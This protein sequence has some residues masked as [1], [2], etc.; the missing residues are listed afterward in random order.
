MYSIPSFLIP[1][2]FFLAHYHWHKIEVLRRIINIVFFDTTK[3]LLIRT[4]TVIFFVVAR[5]VLGLSHINDR[6]HT[7]RRKESV[8][9]KHGLH[10]RKILILLHVAGVFAEPLPSTEN[11][12]IFLLASA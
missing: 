6:E 10:I 9:L 8:S 4:R 12:E 7:D 11:R 1:S 3:E 5:N 2:I